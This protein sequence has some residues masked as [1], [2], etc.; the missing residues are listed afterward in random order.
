MYDK[1]KLDKDKKFVDVSGMYKFCFK[2]LGIFFEVWYLNWLFCKGLIFVCIS[3]DF[4]YY[5][6]K[7]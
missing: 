2:I 6:I 1:R 4:D 5:K 3:I 7:I